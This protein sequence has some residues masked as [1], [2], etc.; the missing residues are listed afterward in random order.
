M[1]EDIATN[2]CMAE[3]IG[4]QYIGGERY[5]NIYIDW[6]HLLQY[7]IYV[8][9]DIAI[10]ISMSEDIA[11]QYIAHILQYTGI[12]WSTPKAPIQ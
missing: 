1:V 6:L 12:Y 4:M 8:V 3:D 10:N 11:I 9:A 2:T 5:C 7:N